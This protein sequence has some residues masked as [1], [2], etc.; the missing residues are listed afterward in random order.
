MQRC[1]LGADE[2][3]CG[4]LAMDHSHLT[5][6]CSEITCSR[7]AKML[8]AVGSYQCAE[9]LRPEDQVTSSSRTRMLTSQV[10]RERESRISTKPLARAYSI[11]PESS[12]G[13]RSQCPVRRRSEA[14]QTVRYSCG[15][16]SL[17]LPPVVLN[18][19]LALPD[20]PEYPRS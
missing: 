13:H 12:S 11:A 5:S 7:L 19:H 3:P 2:T 8:T 16:G 4:Y 6:L 15:A 14:P 20:Q 10:H 17:V 1:G 9:Q 18:D